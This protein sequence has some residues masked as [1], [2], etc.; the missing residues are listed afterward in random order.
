MKLAEMGKGDRGVIVKIEGKSLE[1]ALLRLGLV[2]G[3]SFEVADLA[4]MGGPMA[5][6]VRGTKIALRRNNAH[7]VTVKFDTTI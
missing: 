6:Q 4:P 5:L 3:D 7:H 1:M 2:P